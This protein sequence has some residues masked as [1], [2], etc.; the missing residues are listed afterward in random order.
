MNE[1]LVRFFGISKWNSVQVDNQSK[2][3][4][5]DTQAKNCSAFLL[6]SNLEGPI[7]NALSAHQES[8]RIRILCKK[9]A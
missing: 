1:T 5:A 2:N 4:V 7:S 9:R 3:A 8:S 6:F